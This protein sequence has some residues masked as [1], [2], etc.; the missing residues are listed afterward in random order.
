MKKK[1]AIISLVIAISLFAF[2]YAR[3]NK[4]KPRDI[5]IKRYK[6]GDTISYGDFKFSV[7]E[8]ILDDVKDAEKKLLRVK[9]NVTNESL[10]LQNARMIINSTKFCLGLFS[11][12]GQ[13]IL[14][15]GFPIEESKYEFNYTLDDLEME[16]KSNKSFYV[17]YNIEEENIGK[18]DSCILFLNDLYMDKYS[19]K[20]EDDLTFYYEILDLKG[21]L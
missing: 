7:D 21:A 12:I 14:E 3:A 11:D 8:V 10:D 4:G 5:E 9:Y 17:Y 15:P 19:E 16:S 18:L 1:T 20:L 6:I 13:N 2:G